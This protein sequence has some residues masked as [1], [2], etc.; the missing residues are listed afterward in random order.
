M[1]KIDFIFISLTSWDW[2]FQREQ[3]LASGFAKRGHKVLFI[4]SPISISSF[5]KDIKKKIGRKKLVRALDIFEIEKNLFL[6]SP[7]NIIS[8]R[9]KPQIQ[10]ILNKILIKNINRV[11]KKLNF[12]NVVIFAS[13]PVADL[14]ID[15]IKKD[16]VCFDLIDEYKGYNSASLDLITS[17]LEKKLIKKSDIIFCTAHKLFTRT[18]TK[19]N[20]VYLVPNA[21]DIK[22]YKTVFPVKTNNKVPV[23]GF[24]GYLEP[25]IW[26]LNLLEYVIKQRHNYKFVFVGLYN[27]DAERFK[28]YINVQMTGR[29]NFN[30][31]INNLKKFDVCLIPFN[32]NELIECINPVKMYEYLATGKPIV[33]TNLTEP[34]KFSNLIYITDSKEEFV[35]KIDTVLIE[36]DKKLAVERIKTASENN[37]DNRVEQILS[38][39]ANYQLMPEK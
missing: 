31:L 4:D 17:N 16:L 30:E 18:K 9:H 38:I 26:N 28:K 7:V 29:V 39:I 13:T 27:K 12:K 21:V 20:K 33:S 3:H 11:I 5:I 8:A 14:F 19:H 25:V 15:N 36:N 6:H 34:S 1:K 23:I 2:H 37:W 24:V 35:K 22:K 32:K 10:E